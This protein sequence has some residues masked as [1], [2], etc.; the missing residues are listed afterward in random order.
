MPNQRGTL[1]KSM[2]TYLMEMNT[3]LK[4]FVQIVIIMY[5][6]SQKKRYNDVSTKRWWWLCHGL[7]L[8]FRCASIANLLSKLNGIINT[9]KY[10]W[11]LIHHERPSE[12]YLIGKNFIFLPDN[13]LKHTAN[14]VKSYLNRKTHEEKLSVIDWPSWSLTLKIIEVVWVHLDREWNKRQATF[15]ENGMSFKKHGELFLKST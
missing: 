5:R 11:I 7:R 3:N 12:K 4:I 1:W 9:E 2:A 14:A 15:K 13:D 10:H 8:Y 6:G